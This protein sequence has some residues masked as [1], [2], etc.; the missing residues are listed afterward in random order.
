[1]DSQDHVIAKSV[2]QGVQKFVL[3]NNRLENNYI[4]KIN[5]NVASKEH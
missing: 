4:V 2:G 3:I 1:M 5:M